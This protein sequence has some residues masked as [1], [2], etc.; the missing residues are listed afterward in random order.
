MA[1]FLLTAKLYA[2]YYQ[3][4]PFSASRYG[5][6]IISTDDLGNMLIADGAKLVKVDAEGQLLNHYYSGLPGVI[7]SVDCKDP[8]RILVFI[9]DYASAIFLDQELRITGTVSNFNYISDPEPISL[10]AINL[11]YATMACLHDLQE[12]WWIYDNNTSDLVLMDSDNQIDFKGDALDQLTD[13]SPEPNF[14]LMEGK[15]LF[16]NNP[17]TGLYIF[18]ENGSF[19]NK[20]PLL[21]LKKFQVH[22]N[23]LFYTSNS[24]LV[25][26]DMDNDKETFHPLPVIGFTDWA[27][28][29]SSFPNK[30]AF[31]SQQGVQ[32]FTLEME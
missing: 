11:G 2:Q 23:I 6:R 15:R 30:I 3:F 1:L 17:S 28:S 18:D 22:K 32:I 31:L 14:M 9:K 5:G 16:I 25:A 12:A 19:V 29:F 20:L 21:G 4:I 10:D 13:L 26:Y 8:R 7:T 24:F 27:L